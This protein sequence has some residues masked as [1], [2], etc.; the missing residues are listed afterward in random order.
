MDGVILGYGGGQ[1]RRAASPTAASLNDVALAPGGGWAV[2][3]K[4]VIL[5]LGPGQQRIWLPTIQQG[6]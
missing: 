5:R 1:W 2:G 3:D 4:G 6:K